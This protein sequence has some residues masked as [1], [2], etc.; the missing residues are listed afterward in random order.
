MATASLPISSPPYIYTFCQRKLVVLEIARV[1]IIKRAW[2]SM[3]E[4]VLT[5]YRSFECRYMW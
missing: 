3:V 4:R 1:L 2:Y 5:V